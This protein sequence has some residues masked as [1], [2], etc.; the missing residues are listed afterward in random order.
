MYYFRRLSGCCDTPSW[1]GPTVR[2]AVRRYCG[3]CPSDTIQKDA[4]VTTAV[5]CVAGPPRAPDYS[6]ENGPVRVQEGEVAN[7]SS[8]H[9]ST[10]FPNH[11]HDLA[12][13]SNTHR[14]HPFRY[15]GKLNLAL[16]FRAYLPC[17]R[18]QKIQAPSADIDG[19]RGN[20]HMRLAFLRRLDETV[21]IQFKSVETS[22]FGGLQNVLTI[23][24]GSAEPKSRAGEHFSNRLPKIVLADTLRH[25]KRFGF[26]AYSG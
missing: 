3:G 10:V 6:E 4:F 16:Q 2:H 5:R 14:S 22:S 21:E 25:S 13:A 1:S 23:P 17:H 19:L 8:N 15:L 9:K 18:G 12:V 20:R 26:P 7:G 24:T 11:P